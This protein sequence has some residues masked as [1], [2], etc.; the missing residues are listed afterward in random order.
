[1]SEDELKV[2]Y[3]I[4]FTYIHPFNERTVSHEESLLSLA[5]ALLR[6]GKIRFELDSEEEAKT[7]LDRASV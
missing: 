5:M 2:Y 1:M 4:R 7:S 3:S 6:A